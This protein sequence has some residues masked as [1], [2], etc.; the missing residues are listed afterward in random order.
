MMR[1]QNPYDRRAAERDAGDSGAT[2]RPGLATM[3]PALDS[4]TVALHG[5]RFSPARRELT[6]HAEDHLAAAD[7]VDTP[8]LTLRD[9]EELVERKVTRARRDGD[10]AAYL[11]ERRLAAEGRRAAWEEGF[12]AGAQH[13]AGEMRERYDEALGES[14]HKIHGYAVELDAAVRLVAG[15]ISETHAG[16]ELDVAKRT[17]RDTTKG[18]LL[19]FIATVAKE[20]D[21]AIH[22]HNGAAVDVAERGGAEIPF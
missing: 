10:D 9:L 2:M 4:G 3:A 21:R 7:E 20:T 1:P 14:I 12:A 17:L 13:G 18:S 15:E 8:R 5:A 19:A 6:A 16:F 22:W 11:R